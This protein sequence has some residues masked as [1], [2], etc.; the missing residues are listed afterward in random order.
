MQLFDERREHLQRVPHDTE[1]GEFEDWCVLVS[2]DRN[3]C[4]RAFHPDCVLHG[5]TDTEGKIDGDNITF[6]QVVN[7]NG[8]DMKILYTSKADTDGIKFTR[9]VGDRPAV[10]F[11]ATR[12][13]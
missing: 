7:F 1:V 11:T 10:N 12:P 5:S 8:S 9:T 6:T 2:V 4:F 3:N 13:K